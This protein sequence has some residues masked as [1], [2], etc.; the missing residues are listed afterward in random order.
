MS[1]KILTKKQIDTQLQRVAFKPFEM[2]NDLLGIME[3]C[4]HKLYLLR[5]NGDISQ[6]WIA[7]ILTTTDAISQLELQNLLGIKSGSI[8]EI[9]IKMEKKGY[10]T[11]SKDLND[12]R[13]I[14][15]RITESG[16]NWDANIQKVMLHNEDRQ[17]WFSVL[18][19]SEKKK[20]QE[21]L[22]RLMASWEKT[23]T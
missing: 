2:Q 16:R 8:S 10:I 17:S 9:I 21:M 13:R 18:N 4:S 11:R 14:V 3:K 6:R 5:S 12:K 19:S 23:N 15:L 20:L 7:H 1:K 22:M